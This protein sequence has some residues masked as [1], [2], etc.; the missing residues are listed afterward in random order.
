V[1]GCSRPLNHYSI[2]PSLQFATLPAQ[3]GEKRFALTRDLP[4]QLLSAVA[5][6]ASPRLCPVFVS[7]ISSRMGI[8]N[9]QQLEV[10]FPIWT[11]LLEWWIAETSFHPRRY[12]SRIDPRLRHVVLILAAGDRALAERL[13]I[14]R[15]KQR[16][17]LPWFNAS[18]DEIAHGDRPR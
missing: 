17:F 3:L 12:A 7:A 2:T 9:R 4:L 15:P 8:L 11:F 16:L 14:D 6:A 13:I 18:F 5:I 10:F 1:G